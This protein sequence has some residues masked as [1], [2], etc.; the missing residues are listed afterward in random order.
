M[1]TEPS[2]FLLP[3]I[4]ECASKVCLQDSLGRPERKVQVSMM[5]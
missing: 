1:K 4:P 3:V 5:L 2:E